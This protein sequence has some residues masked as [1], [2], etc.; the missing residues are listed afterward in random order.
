MGRA[1]KAARAGTIEAVIGANKTESEGLLTPQETIGEP[2][3]GLFTRA[4]STW[5][6]TSMASLKSVRLAVITSYSYFDTLDAYI[7]KQPA[8]VVVFSGDTPLDDAL[9][10]LEKGEVDV[11]AETLP[12]FVWHVKARHESMTD[13]HLAYTHEGEPIYV[14]FAKTDD[15]ARY[16]TL[17]DARL[18]A[19]RKSGEL[20]K[21]LEKYGLRDWR[22]AP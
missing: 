7:A 9:T 17:F 12:V 20:A 2:K 18:R 19:L 22:E 3:V 10:K 6:Y 8:N 16:A 1:L 14:A 4:N 21:I 5:H 11:V 13:Y 15:G